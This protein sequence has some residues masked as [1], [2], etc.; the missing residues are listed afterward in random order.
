LLG[1]LGAGALGGGELGGGEL[2]GE[3]GGGLDGSGL[4]GFKSCPRARMTEAK[5][6]DVNAKVKN[7]ML[8][9]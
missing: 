2:G 9:A 3:L 8:A 5:T 1:A 7:A 6:N 4:S